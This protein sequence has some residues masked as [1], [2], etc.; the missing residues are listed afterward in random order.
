MKNPRMTPYQPTEGGTDSP[1]NTPSPQSASDA[2]KRLLFSA[3]EAKLIAELEAE[4]ARADRLE[5]A[6]RDIVTGDLWLEDM[7]DTARAAL[8]DEVET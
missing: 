3:Y 1:K 7:V 2:G 8:G 4:R 5:A 6:L